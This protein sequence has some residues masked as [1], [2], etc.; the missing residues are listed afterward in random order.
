MGT[1]RKLLIANRGEIATRIMRTCHEMGIHSVAVYSDADADAPFVQ[2]ADESVRIG[3]APSAESYLQVEALI[4]AAQKTG[5]DAIHP[6]YGFL[7]ENAAFADAVTKAGLI[8]V[9]PTSNAIRV[10]G[11]KVESK[12]LMRE[13]G[14]PVIPGFED[15]SASEEKLLE[16]AKEIGFPLLIK[17]SAGG[18]G[19]GMRLVRDGE[20]LEK[21]LQASAREAEKSFGDGTLL[22]ERYIEDPRHIEFQVFGDTHGNVVHLFERECS[23]Q[24]R[25]Q[26]I[27]EETPSTAMTPALRE[28][29]GEAAVQAANS[30]GY[31]GAG[32]VEFILAPD[33]Q[34]YFLEMNTRLQVE[35]PITEC[36]TGIDL[37]REQ[38]QVAQGEP[39][40][41]DQATLQIN[42]AAIECRIYAEDPANDFLPTIGNLVDWHL[43][44]MTGLRLDTGVE[45]GSAVSIYYDPMLAK[46]IASGRNREE[47]IQRMTRA[48]QD[49]SIQGIVTNRRF[50]IQVLQHDA[51]SSGEISTHFINTH[52][53]VIEA[54]SPTDHTLSTHA[55]VATA[56]A[57][58]N[59]TTHRRL[60]SLRPGWR[61][62][63]FGTQ[64]AK[65]TVGETEIT[66]AYESQADNIF[67]MTAGEETTTVHILSISGHEAAVEIDGIRRT[68][69]AIHQSGSWYI[70]SP[71]GSTTLAVSPRFSDGQGESSQADCIAPMPG[72]ILEVLVE[73]GQSVSQGDTIATMEAMKMEHAVTTA[74][75]GVIATVLVSPGDQVDARAP[76]VI[77]EEQAE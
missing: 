66:I 24:R 71:L 22:L 74:R 15:A 2:L 36:I 73:A 41:I 52:F 62:N 26:K 75:D 9:G 13:A 28:T 49:M 35:H 44:E 67:E 8:F 59:R 39:L 64:S 61:N 11:S 17:A 34:Y 16:A 32:T 54:D 29:M 45:T 70:H 27:I 60:P 19:K 63:P 56:L 5:A 25:H 58:Q 33:G 30:I 57:S 46:V 21:E 23:I 1:I 76:L 69:R 18:G 14:V 43:P 12:K 40:S 55:M 4:S 50:L 20:G 38:I 3:P 7:A 48:L 37:V 10:M 47:A 53:P 6:G 31:I 42:G 77:L 68:Y 65:Y 51:F 72:K